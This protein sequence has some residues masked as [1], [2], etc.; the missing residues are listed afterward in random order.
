MPFA[1]PVITCAILP[2]YFEYSG[3]C[4]LQYFGFFVTFLYSISSPIS[5][6]KNEFIILIRN[7]HP[8]SFIG[9]MFSC[10]L[11]AHS[12]MASWDT[13]PLLVLCAGPLSCNVSASP[14]L[15]NSASLAERQDGPTLGDFSI[16]FAG[17]VSAG[18]YRFGFTLCGC[19]GFS[20]ELGTL[21]GVKGGRGGRKT[22]VR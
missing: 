22:M 3:S 15:T 5:S 10:I 16:L 21:V 6:F 2:S 9:D 8:A 1:C 14:C 12:N 19:E 11:S 13:V 20:V 7:L 17:T 18:N 4:N